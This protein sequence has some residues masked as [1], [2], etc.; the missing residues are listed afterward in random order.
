MGVTF[1]AG[2]FFLG[3]LLTTVAD[4]FTLRPARAEG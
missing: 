1:V 3:G 4:L 2:T